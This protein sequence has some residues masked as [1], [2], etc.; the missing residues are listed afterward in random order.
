MTGYEAAE[1]LIQNH[2]LSRAEFRILLGASKDPAVC[3]RLQAEA[4]RL[5]R[6]YYGKKVF[7]RGL[8]EFTNYC[9]NNC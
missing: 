8:I 2:A 6:L 3:K 7:A 9:R 4:V 1:K 5:R